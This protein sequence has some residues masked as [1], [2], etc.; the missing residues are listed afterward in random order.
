MLLAALAAGFL[1]FPS[2]SQ[3]HNILFY[4]NS[5]DGTDGAL[6]Q[7]VTILEKSG[8]QVTTI[9]E[10][11]KNRN[12]ANDNWD[13]PYDQVWDMRFV[14]RDSPECGSGSPSAADY[15]DAHWRQ[16]AVSF[17]NHCGNL[18]IAAEHYPLADR[19]EGLYVFLKQ[20]QAVKA[21]YDSCPPSERGNDSTTGEAFYPVK[22]HLGPKLFYGAWVGGIPLDYLNGTSFVET[23]KDWEGDDAVRSVVS[24]WKDSQL[25]GAVTA[26][27]CNRG[28]LFMVWDATMW[29]LWQ[30]GMYDE[31]AEDS[32][33]I[34]DDS[35]WQPW[36]PKNLTKTRVDIE[37]AK[38]V[39]RIFFSAVAE[40]LGTRGCPC[41]QTA[42]VSIVPTATPVPVN[43]LPPTQL[44]PPLPT[45]LSLLSVANQS[46]TI[47]APVKANGPATITFSSF[48]VNIYMGFRDGAGKYQLCILDSYGRLIKT[49]FDTPIW[50]QKEAWASWDGT[51]INGRQ[52]SSTGTFYAVLYK[53]SRPLR[54]IVLIRIVGM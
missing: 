42:S 8:N 34:W 5:Q 28:K 10:D 9:D 49:V 12:P 7:C 29:T 44:P 16:K 33:P 41:T 36:S 1:L 25:G 46:S 20:I 6:L 14:E 11:G 47:T 52:S 27:S 32:P 22:H 43:Q 13:A 38:K 24:G 4:Y 15:F 30:K 53:D 2:S 19:D 48:P 18:F 21:G 50:A 45:P 37:K 31:E 35:A 39:T 23:G 51:D 17:L 3:A 26:V 40:W 54:K